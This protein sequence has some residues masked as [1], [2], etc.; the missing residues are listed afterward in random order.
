[1]SDVEEIPDGTS[2][3]VDMIPAKFPGSH[4]REGVIVTGIAAGDRLF[5]AWADG[6]QSVISRK[7]RAEKHD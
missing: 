6:T 4:T 1:M 7:I 3:D 5:I 2:E